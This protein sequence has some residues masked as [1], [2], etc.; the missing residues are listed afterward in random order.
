MIGSERQFLLED[1]LLLVRDSGEIPEIAY[2]GA[3]HYLSHDAEGP[4]LELN[5]GEL[6]MLQDAAMA[7]Y[8][9]II[10]RD[11]DP[12]SRD[13]SSYRGLKRAITNY[14]RLTAF[15]HR[16]QRQPAMDCDEVKQLLLVFICRELQE[17]RHGLRDSSVNCSCEELEAF[18]RQLSFHENEL[19]AGWRRLCQSEA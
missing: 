19:P 16:I 15:S 6:K 8:R 7:R 17:V 11:L 13:L 2:Q 5:S 14:K 3:L 1:E 9:E 12:G 18:C 4:G 10:L